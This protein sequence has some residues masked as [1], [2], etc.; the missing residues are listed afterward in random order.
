MTS[1]PT[2]AFTSPWAP[3]RVRVFRWLW[4]ASVVS[5]IGTT[6]HTAAAAWAMTE[7][8]DSPT[9]ISLV[10]VAWGIPGVLI[11]IPSGA[12]AD[13][14]DRR[15]LIVWSQ[16]GSLA[17]A[18]ALGVLDLTGTLGI[19]SLLI[20]T[21]VLSVVMTL[22]GPAFMALIPELVGPEELPLA[23]GLNN[24]SYN[25]SQSVGPALAGVLIATAGAGAVFVLNALSFLGIV[26]VLLVMKPG[27]H[28]PASEE[29]LVAAMRTGVTYF[30]TS[31]RPKRFAL[32]IMAS[33]LVASSMVALL[34]VNTS[35]R[36]DASPAEYGFVAAAFGVG[37]VLA[38]WLLPRVR[39]VASPDALVMGA[40]V[41]W[42]IGTV[43]VAA[44]ATI[45]A[46]VV[47]TLL[48]GAA[49]MA[50]M[51]VTYSMFM[52]M[53]PMWIRGR[54]SSVVMLVVWVGL[55]VGSFA[56]GALADGIGLATTFLVAA[57]LHLAVTGVA[58]ALFPLG[59]VDPIVDDSAEADSA[60]ADSA[61]EPT[62][63]SA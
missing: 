4:V 19:N 34:P 32:R 30:R 41:V 9:I 40:S 12:L 17:A 33:Y 52:L 47:G 56:W 10:Q 37:A 54:A 6:M 2:R 5:N 63:H 21:F 59:H 35:I 26:A 43:I 46:A 60:D 53:L 58:T 25:G 42:A 45:T 31:D 1:P 16:L 61:G 13:V 18:A 57:V 14:V 22:S 38:V 39:A 23:I 55:S 62:D 3:L 8:T 48:T 24:I 15:R 20:A 7:L 28:G 36:L 49:T 44:S 51:N 27:R 50:A 29:R 11:A